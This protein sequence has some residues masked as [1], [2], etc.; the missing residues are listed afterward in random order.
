MTIVTIADFAAVSEDSILPASGNVLTNDTG[1]VLS[2]ANP[3]M[4][5]GAHGRIV[6]AADGSYTYTLDT[7]SPDVQGLRQGEVATEVYQYLASDGITST[8]GLLTVQIVG[9]NDAPVTVND[10]ATMGE[11]LAV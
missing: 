6:L 11:D 7:A 1:T 8:P 5:F 10:I 3:G 2:V 4:F 9:S